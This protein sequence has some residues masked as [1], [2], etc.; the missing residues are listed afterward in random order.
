MSDVVYL[1]GEMAP[2]LVRQL[3]KLEMSVCVTFVYFSEALAEKG[4]K[5]F[6]GRRG[7]P[8]LPVKPASGDG[9]RSSEGLR[10]RAVPFRELALLSGFRFLYNREIRV[11]RVTCKILKG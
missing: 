11:T 7:W 8:A 9:E 4:G 5:V 6:P 2:R 10:A 3:A 1:C